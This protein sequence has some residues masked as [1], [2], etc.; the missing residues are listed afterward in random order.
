MGWPFGEWSGRAFRPA[1][2][3]SSAV[4]YEQTKLLGLPKL[5]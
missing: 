2:M 3:V 1:D 5:V 4:I